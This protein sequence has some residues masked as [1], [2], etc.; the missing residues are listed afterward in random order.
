[1]ITY[2]DHVNIFTDDLDETVAFYEGV[3]GMTAGPKPSGKPGIW[4]FVD[5]RAVIHVNIV[6]QRAAPA[7]AN[8]NH[9]AFSATDLASTTAALEAAAVTHDIVERP[10][11][12]ITQIMCTDPNGI[13]LELNVPTPF[14]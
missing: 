1:M 14:S 5:G 7:P 10:D 6:D 4:L 8:L 9:V 12:G 11:L 13:P 2:L 3:L